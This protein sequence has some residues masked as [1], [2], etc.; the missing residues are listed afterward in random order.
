LVNSRNPHFTATRQRSGR[1]ALHA[2]RHTFS[3]SY[4]VSL[5]SSLTRVLSRALE[6]SPRPP[7][8][9]C[10]TGTTVSHSAAF[11]GSME[12]PSCEPKLTS[13]PLG[14]ASP[15]LSLSRPTGTA[16]GLEPGPTKRLARPTLLRPCSA[17]RTVGGAGILTCLPSPTPFGLSLG[18]D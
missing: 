14:V 2:S 3:R 9:V 12:S 7:E 16:Y 11:L 4:G 10:G 15:R 5:P 17:K 13:S 8:S 18:P 6:Y 1:K